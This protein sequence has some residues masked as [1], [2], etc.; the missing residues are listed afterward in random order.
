MLDRGRREVTLDG[1]VLV[2]THRE[3]DLLAYLV[4]QRGLALSRRQLLDGAW[5][6]DWYGDERTVDVHVAQL[7]RKLAGALTLTTVRGTGYRLD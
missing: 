5:G 1:E 2:L 6:D 3:F 7:R 4:L